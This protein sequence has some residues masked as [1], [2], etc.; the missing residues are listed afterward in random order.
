[1]CREVEA[2]CEVDQWRSTD[3]CESCLGFAIQGDPDR[4]VHVELILEI[5]VLSARSFL[6]ANQ[7]RDFLGSWFSVSRWAA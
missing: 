3:S 1:M 2:L 7:L 4:L 6:F 5:I